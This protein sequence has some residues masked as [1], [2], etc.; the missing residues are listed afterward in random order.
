MQI[1][2]RLI[3]LACIILL[4]SF[5]AGTKYQ[6]FCTKKAARE[7]EQLSEL[8]K[9][10]D[11]EPIP[12]STA[13]NKPM[14]QVYICG[15]VEKPGMY[16][17]KDGD[18]LYQALEIA[19]ASEGAELKYL[20]MARELIDGETIIVPPIG[21]NP[22]EANQDP[23]SYLSDMAS[24]KI[25]INQ[26]NVGDLDRELPGVGPVIAQ[27]IVDYRTAHGAFKKIEDLKNVDGIGDKI[28]NNLKDKV[29]VR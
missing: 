7:Q 18:R 25:N 15:E 9:P 8:M 19:G 20:G 28:F 2:R 24:G 17:L 21:G 14:I 12:N 6:Q 1:D 11:S 10:S 13:D 23:A 29:T 4:L 26:A 22:S 16:S 3:A 27:R 5:F